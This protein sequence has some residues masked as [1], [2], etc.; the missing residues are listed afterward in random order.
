MNYLDE[1]HGLSFIKGMSELFIPIVQRLMG[2]KGNTHGPI[3]SNKT[4]N[5]TYIRLVKNYLA[6]IVQADCAI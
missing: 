2:D 4:S 3:Q 1:R 5:R 6:D